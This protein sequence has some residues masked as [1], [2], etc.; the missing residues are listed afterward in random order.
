MPTRDAIAYFGAG[1]SGLPTPIA[2]AASSAFLNYDNTGL[3]LAEL[4]HR[5]PTATQILADARAALTQLLDIPEN[6]EILFCHGGGSGEFSAVVLNLVPVW[7][8]RRRRVAVKE[9]SSSS[10]SS[11]GS[12]SDNLE[13]KVLERVRRE[14]RERLRLDYLVT[15]SWSLKASQEAALLL[16]PLGGEKLVNVAVDA[17]EESSDGASF[18][19]IPAEEKWRLTKAKGNGGCASAL[20][21][22]CDNE[23]VDGVEFPGFPKALDS[24][25]EGK[26]G[27]RE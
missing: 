25:E 21:Y 19:T 7:V 9:L 20:V 6:Y 26:G 27:G 5:S 17:R 23:T 14:V 22:Y 12:G 16:G 8:E 2:T 13:E 4:S 10:S 18:K 15:G 1:P 11:V 3:G 24:E